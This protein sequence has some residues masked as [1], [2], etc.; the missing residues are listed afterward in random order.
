MC[1]RSDGPNLVKCV[2]DTDNSVHL[3]SKYATA[4]HHANLASFPS[5]WERGYMPTTQ[6]VLTTQPIFLAYTHTGPGHYDCA[7]PD[8]TSPP[9]VPKCACGRNPMNTQVPWRCPC[10]RDKT[11]CSDRCRCKGCTNKYGTRPPPSTTRRRQ[12]YDN[13]KQPLQGTPISVF[14]GEPSND[15]QLTLLEVLLFK[16]SI[17]GLDEDNPVAGTG[18]K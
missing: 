1:W 9:E 15:G 2:A 5:A 17:I 8:L 3:C 16:K 13:Q 7:L 4:L 10:I 18:T 14:E 6:T 12:T 11:E